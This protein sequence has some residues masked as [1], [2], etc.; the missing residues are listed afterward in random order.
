MAIKLEMGEL[1]GMNN[2]IEVI[3]AITDLKMIGMSDDDIQKVL[4]R[5]KERKEENNGD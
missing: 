1:Y 3:E 2:I 5:S 4:E